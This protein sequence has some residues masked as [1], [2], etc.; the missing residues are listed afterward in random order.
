MF[1]TII[2]SAILSFSIVSSAFA[3]DV[4]ENEAYRVYDMYTGEPIVD[5]AF[6]PYYANYNGTEIVTLT[7][8]DKEYGDCIAYEFQNVI[9]EKIPVENIVR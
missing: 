6:E 9:L 1:K 3:F 5:I 2:T 4:N 8:C 7:V